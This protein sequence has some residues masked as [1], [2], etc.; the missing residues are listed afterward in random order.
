MAE[1]D[2]DE[3]PLL[4]WLEAVD[5]DEQPAGNSRAA[6]WVGGGLVCALIFALGVYVLQ[7]S[8]TGP[9]LVSSPVP[10]AIPAPEP[11]PAPER[12]DSGKVATA[13]AKPVPP[14]L[15]AYPLPSVPARVPARVQKQK[16]ARA[17]TPARRDGL[18]PGP[19]IQLA[20]HYS[21]R[22]AER[23]WDFLLQRHKNLARLDHAV[24]TG[25]VRGRTVYRL[26]ASGANAF[27]TCGRLRSARVGCLQI[28]H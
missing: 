14:R 5:E 12:D 24:V 22:R 18:R 4:P 10:E 21:F 27:E 9:D 15:D 23:H 25:S 16:T 2:D 6:F 13:P 11:I 28:G 19:T 26:R 3:V 1:R 17:T 7:P 8:P 20:S